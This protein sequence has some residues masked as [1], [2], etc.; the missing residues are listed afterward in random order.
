MTKTI[1]EG[2]RAAA[3]AVKLC[4]PK[5][6][7]AYP[8]TPQTHIVE[9]LAKLI[10]DG[11]LDCEYVLVESEFSAQS[12][13]QGASATG[14]RTYTATA[15]Q[16]LS[17]M[18][19]VLGATSGM[20]L[21]VVM[22]VANRALS[23]PINIWNDQ[24]DT[25]AVRDCGWIQ[26]YCETIQ[27]VVDK[28][29]QAYKIAENHKVLL[30]VMV[31]M[32]GFILT[33]TT[34]PV[35][36]P[37]QSE[38]DSFLPEYKP[39]FKLDSDHPVTMGPVGFPTDYYKFRIQQ[40]EAMKNSLKIIEDCSKEFTKEFNRGGNGLIEEYGDGD[41]VIISLGSVCGTIKDIID[42]TDNIRLIKLECFRPFPSKELKKAVNNASAIGVLE[43]DISIGFGG[44][45]WGEVKAVMQKENIPII[46]FI[47]GL[48]G[49]DI[50][51][52]N[53]RD[54]FEVIKAAGLGKDVKE[55]NWI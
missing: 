35:D 2:S 34:E 4:K 26:L 31:C 43:K 25:I 3:E 28:T 23:A 8:I 20:R 39:L 46:N 36:I 30:P 40:F 45:I 47:A 14:V 38:V 55:I 29:I 10:A 49:R 21:P 7:A 1:V 41:N 16:G 22:T 19:E 27:E 18:Y 9:D 54:C 6:I 32:D 42:E 52:P 33:H 11:E 13:V 37:E 50:T 5:L 44:A 12:A 48:G 24:Q 17:L 53:I 51:L 15:S